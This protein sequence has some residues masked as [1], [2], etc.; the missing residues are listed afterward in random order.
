MLDGSSCRSYPQPA[1]PDARTIEDVPLWFSEHAVA[2]QLAFGDPRESLSRDLENADR[3]LELAVEVADRPR[4][5]RFKGKRAE[6]VRHLVSPRGAAKN[7]L[8]ELFGE[9]C[10]S[11]RAK[12]FIQMLRSKVRKCSTRGPLP[13]EHQHFWNCAPHRSLHRAHLAFAR[14]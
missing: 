3:M 7:A 4:R 2:W 13:R 5:L 6:R 14:R 1:A 10:P 9:D 8:D 11:W 12:R